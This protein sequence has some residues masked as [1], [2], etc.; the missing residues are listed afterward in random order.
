[1]INNK[2]VLILGAGASCDYGFPIGE[3]LRDQICKEIFERNSVFHYLVGKW[4][5]P[6]LKHFADT[7]LESRISVDAFLEGHPDYLDMG[8]FAIASI[9]LPIEKKSSLYTD[10]LDP[11]KVEGKKHW[12]DILFHNL[13]EGTDFDNFK[14]NKLSVITFNYDRS[15]EEFLFNS[16]RSSR[17]EA[18]KKENEAGCIA[19]VSSVEVVHVYGSLGRL[20]WQP[21][22]GLLNGVPKVEYSAL[23]SG[24][25]LL[26]KIPTINLAAKSI[27]IV[28]DGS[29]DTPAFARAKELLNQAQRIYILGFG[30]NMKNLERLGLLD[31]DFFTEEIVGTAHGLTGQLRNEIGQIQY[32]K[33]LGNQQGNYLTRRFNLFNQTVYEFLYENS[34]AVLSDLLPKRL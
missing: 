30:F 10:W 28:R 26:L 11:K 29:G 17:R 34:N 16:F 32:S 1:M 6:K 15:F 4:G 22:S 20:P 13:I 3:G 7:L 23:K 18:K 27:D 31:F 21:D 24:G 2:T 14:D 25:D 9:L 33:P 5:A 12:Y 8:K 19:Q